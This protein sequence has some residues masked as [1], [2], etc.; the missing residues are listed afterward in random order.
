MA[1]CRRV[2]M[3]PWSGQQTVQ[4]RL[5]LGREGE[6]LSWLISGLVSD[7]GQNAII[8]HVILRTTP[9]TSDRPEHK[10]HRAG[11]ATCRVTFDRIRP[12][13]IERS[14]ARPAQMHLRPCWLDIAPASSANCHVH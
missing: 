8:D 14:H 11:E 4:A 6:A 3:V 12:P 2:G 9:Q 13:G 5:R 7:I 10:A 1:G